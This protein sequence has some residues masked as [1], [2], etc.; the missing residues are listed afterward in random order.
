VELYDCRD[1]IRAPMNGTCRVVCA[2]NNEPLHVCGLPGVVLINEIAAPLAPVDEDYYCLM[3][4]RYIFLCG[5][6]GAPRE[7]SQ[8][9]LCRQCHWELSMWRRLRGA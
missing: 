6:C 1:P 4:Y 9:D 2:E 5:E 7:S 8:R 3:H